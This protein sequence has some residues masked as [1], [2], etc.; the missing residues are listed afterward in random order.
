MV[1]TNFQYHQMMRQRLFYFLLMVIIMGCNQ[2]KE[3]TLLFVGSY[4]NKKP[5]KGLKV[6]DFNLQ[7][8]EANL[9][10]EADSLTNPSFIRISPDGQYL[11]SV[12]E[13]QMLE[14]GKVAAFSINHVTGELSL[15]NMQDCG[16]RNPVHLE[17]NKAGTYLV[18]SNYT[19]PSLSLFKIESDGSLT[20]YLQLIPFKGSSIV[21]GRQDQAHI[22]S[23]NFSPDNEYLFTHDL[24]SDK[25]RSLKIRN[26]KSSLLRLEI[27]SSLSTSSGSGPR[28]FTFHPNGELAYGINELGG[29]V[30]AYSYNGYGLKWMADYHAY[31]NRESLYRS[32]D[33]HIS[34]DGRFLYASNRGPVEHSIVIFSIDIRSGELDLVGYESTYGEHPR[35]FVIDP[36]GNFLLVANQFSNTVVVY[37]RDPNSGT[38]TKL[39]FEIKIQSP[40]TLQMYTY[41]N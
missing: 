11:Y 23:S 30:T 22:H 29:T 35:N 3:R 12:L 10:F 9:L 1:T 25:I 4:T 34:P 17:I 8:G 13:S 28:H 36:S 14:N 7:S 40:S 15:I 20:D 31:E 21:E 16:G 27:D 38:L 37:K 33:I 6:Y 24:G 32:A 41:K 19:D 26:D 18:N 39:N 5:D 2:K